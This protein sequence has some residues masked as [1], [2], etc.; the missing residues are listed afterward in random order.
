LVNSQ[1]QLRRNPKQPDSRL[2]LFYPILQQWPLQ[3]VI[4]TITLTRCQA[5]IAQFLPIGRLYSAH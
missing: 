2:E 4:V 5:L 1:R 3:Y